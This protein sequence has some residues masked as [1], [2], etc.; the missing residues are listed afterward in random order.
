MENVRTNIEVHFF[1]GDPGKGQDPWMYS[2]RDDR[3]YRRGFRGGATIVEAALKAALAVEQLEGPA[4]TFEA[5]ALLS[6]AAHVIGG[7]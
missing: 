4:A 2:I 7:G 1:R 3:G 6:Q 5:L